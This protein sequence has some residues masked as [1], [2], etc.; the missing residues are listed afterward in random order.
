MVDPIPPWPG[1]FV[2]LG[3]G[4][5]SAGASQASRPRRPALDIFVRAV[6]EPDGAEPAMFVHGLSGSSRNWTDLMDLLSRP[7]ATGPALAG[8]ALDL[9]GFGHSPAVA[10]GDLSI[11]GQAAAVIA[12]LDKR[13]RWPVHLVGNSL[14]GAI[15]TRVAARRPDLVRT[16]T[17]ISP[18][19]PDLR[20]RVMP[21]RVAA[22]SLPGLGR[23][24]LGRFEALSAAERTARTIRDVFVDP[25]LMHPSRLLEEIEEVSRRDGLDYQADV[26]IRSARALVAEYVRRGPG[27]LWR[28]AARVTAPTLVIH[29]SQDR[30]VSPATAARAARV[31]RSGYVVLLPRLGH[32][33]MMERP[34]LVARL[35]R[36]FLAITEASRPGGV[37]L[38]RVPN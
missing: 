23:W 19:L 21:L 22:I 35:M 11:R 18:A 16:L 6:P 27:T 15:C 38:N 13:G 5:R 34:D 20:P 12:L 4:D 17:L 36:E 3:I 32:V 26:L 10:D 14:G 1:E 37:Q 7:G 31:F 8:E 2:R 9:P 28:D 25:G 30:L 24:A 33:A 29:G